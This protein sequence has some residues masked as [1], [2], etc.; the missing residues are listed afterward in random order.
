TGTTGL[1]TIGSGAAIGGN[2]LTLDAGSVAVSDGTKFGVRN[3][4]I[5]SSSVDFGKAPAGQTGLVLGDATLAT[6]EHAETLTLNSLGAANFYGDVAIDLQRKN[7]TFSLNAAS[8]VAVG[9][10]TVKI[11]AG[12]VSLVNNG[13]AAA[14]PPKAGTAKLDTTAN[15]MQRGTGNRA[16]WGCAGARFMGRQQI[17]LGGDGVLT[18]GA[19]ALS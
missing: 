18:A 16:L 19:A 14:G 1:I 2:S 8:L 9:G 3:I 7:S 12:T 5:D 10:G 11:D 17:T 15:D 4:T 6:L 13:T